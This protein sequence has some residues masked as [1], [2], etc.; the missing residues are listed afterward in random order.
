MK[1]STSLTPFPH[2]SM[3]FWV[4]IYRRKTAIHRARCEGINWWSRHARSRE[5]SNTTLSAKAR[6]LILPTA[7]GLLT[8]SLFCAFFFRQ[9]QGSRDKSRCL[10][11]SIWLPR[12]RT[13]GRELKFPVLAGKRH[14]QK[15]QIVVRNSK[16]NLIYAS[17][18]KITNSQLYWQKRQ[19]I[20][21]LPWSGTSV[22]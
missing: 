6:Q 8:R 11:S 9:P 19:E 21:Q 5:V 13:P 1:N 16:S 12:F 14:L 10:L 15:V 2:C 3:G 22:L 4:K 20:K 17:Y 18:T 7:P